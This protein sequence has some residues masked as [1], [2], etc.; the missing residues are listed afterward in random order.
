[1]VFSPSRQGRADSPGLASDLRITF[2][3]VGFV[4]MKEQKGKNSKPVK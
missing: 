4:Q 1:M 3:E 2:E